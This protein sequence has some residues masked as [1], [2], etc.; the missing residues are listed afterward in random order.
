VDDSILFDN[1]TVGA[2]AALRR[3]IVD[4]GVKIP[5]GETIGFDPGKDRERF[6]LSENGVVVVPKGYRFSGLW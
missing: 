1:V 6:T 5:P 2:G 3:C 4:K